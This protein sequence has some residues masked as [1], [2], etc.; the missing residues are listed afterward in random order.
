M[1]ATAM[2]IQV[3]CYLARSKEADEAALDAFLRRLIDDVKPELE[4]ATGREWRFHIGDPAELPAIP[5]E[6]TRPADFVPQS[7]QRLAEGSFDLVVAIADAP[8]V[9]RAERPTSGVASELTRTCVLSTRRLQPDRRGPTGAL[10]APAVRWNAAALLLH[11]IGHAMGLRSHPDTEGVMAPFRLDAERNRCP[12]FADPEQ[13]RRLA[14]GFPEQEWRGRNRA[15]EILLHAFAVV[16][17]PVLVLRTLWRNKAP[18]LPLKMPTL[19]TAAVAPVFIL[20]FTA[21]M[22]DAGLGMKN[23]TAWW[24]AGLSILAATLYLAL[25]LN[26]FL[27]RKENRIV[28]EHIAVANGTIL[29]TM[30]LAI[31]GLFVM[32]T[33]LTLVIVLAIFPEGLISTWP[34]LEDPVVTWVDKLRLAVFDSTVGVT[35]GALAGGL[36]RREILRELALFPTYV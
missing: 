22:W 29:L 32:V 33:L 18:L 25:S 26:L 21:E 5:A 20:V 24:Y 10:D 15:H 31:V 1:A 7:T 19:A 8:L 30:L 13:L 17:H 11:L 6:G 3:G 35:T 23:A 34:T 36:Q 14:D 27:P 9:S 28:P 4:R 2:P 12:R 16:S